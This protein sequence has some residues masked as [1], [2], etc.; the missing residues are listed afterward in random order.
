LCKRKASNP[1]EADTL[2]IKWVDQLLPKASQ[3][4]EKYILEASEANKSGSFF[5]PPSR[6]GKRAAVMSRLLSEA[7][8]AVYTIGSLVIVCPAA[9]MNAI[10]PLLHTI[11]T[12]G[13]SDP[14]FNKLPGPTASL[15]QTAPSLYIQ[16]WLTMGKICLADGKLAKKYIPLFVQVW[17]FDLASFHSHGFE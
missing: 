17:A 15:K 16:A 2:V 9:D 4:L 12:S 14:K 10:T 11:I 13:N 6:K 7:V 3:I 8:T 5:T 1:E